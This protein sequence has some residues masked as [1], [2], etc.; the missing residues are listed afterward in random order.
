MT[1]P[2]LP[3][4]RDLAAAA[5]LVLAG[6]LLGLALNGLHNALQD[7]HAA[8][9]QRHGIERGINLGIALGLPSGDR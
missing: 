4:R 2:K 5:L 6:S 7:S 8:F 1:R 3:T 9:F